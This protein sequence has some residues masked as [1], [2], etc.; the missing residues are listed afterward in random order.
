MSLTLRKVPNISESELVNLV[1]SLLVDGRDENRTTVYETPLS[2][3]A[4]SIR[5]AQQKSV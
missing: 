2:L 3:G 4:M 1:L 5:H